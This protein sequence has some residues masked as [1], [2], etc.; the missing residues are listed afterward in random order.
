MDYAHKW[1]V[2]VYFS[3]GLGANLLLLL[4]CAAYILDMRREISSLKKRINGKF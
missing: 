1:E 4:F 2:I 3:I